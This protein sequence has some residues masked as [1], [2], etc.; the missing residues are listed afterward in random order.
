MWSAHGFPTF[1]RAFPFPFLSRHPDVL[2]GLGGQADH[3]VQ[4]EVRPA[5]FEGG[6]GGFQQIVFG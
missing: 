4:L 1:V 3:E 5:T 6:G 2:G